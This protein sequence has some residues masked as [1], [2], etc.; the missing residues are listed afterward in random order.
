MTDLNPLSREQIEWIADSLEASIA[1]LGYPVGM[2]IAPNRVALLR[3]ATVIAETHEEA[4]ADLTAKA[5]RLV[6][7]AQRLADALEESRAVLGSIPAPLSHPLWTRMCNAIR[8]AEAELADWNAK[9]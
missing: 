2:G 3:A 9:Q 4:S 7:K 5:E 1:N 6:A 8:K